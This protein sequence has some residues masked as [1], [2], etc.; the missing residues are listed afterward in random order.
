MKKILVT[1]FLSIFLTGCFTSKKP[2]NLNIAAAYP[3]EGRYTASDEIVVNGEKTEVESK[4]SIWILSSKTLYSLLTTVSD[5]KDKI[6]FG[7]K[8]TYVFSK[9]G[10]FIEYKRDA[11][12]DE[13]YVWENWIVPTNGVR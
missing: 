2:A 6:T 10:S 9:D 8:K 13:E 1:A 12:D 7:N 4:D 5:N 11:F 3:F